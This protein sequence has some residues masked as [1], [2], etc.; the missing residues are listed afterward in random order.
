MKLEITTKFQVEMDEAAIDYT[1]NSKFAIRLNLYS[2][3]QK[4]FFINLN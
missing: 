3:S 4:V 2:S 1:V